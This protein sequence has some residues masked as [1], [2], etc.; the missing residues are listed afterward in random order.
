MSYSISEKLNI[1]QLLLFALP[2][3]MMFMFMSFYSIV[4]GIFIARYVS[5]DALAGLNIAY[6]VVGILIAVTFMF[7]SGGSAF[8]AHRMGMKRQITANRSFTFIALSVFIFSLVF[9][10]LSIIFVEEICSLLGANDTLLPYATTYL[11]ILMLFAPLNAMQWLFQCF[12]VTA[13]KPNLG[14]Y[15]TFIGG[16]LN[17]IFD[18]IFIVHMEMGISGAAYATVISWVAP[19]VGS[20][21][22]FMHN[23]AGLTFAKPHFHAIILGK[24]MFNG[25][26][27]MVGQLSQSFTS[28]IFNILMMKYVG[29]IGVAAIT[30]ALYADFLMMSAFFGF[31]IGV[32]PIISYHYGAKNMDYLKATVKKLFVIIFIASIAIYTI[33]VFGSPY[34]VGIFFEENSDVYIFAK[35]GLIIYSIS[36]LFK[37]INV[38]GSA[39]FTALGNGL[40][41]GIL[42]FF[43]T[44]LFLI[45]NIFLFSYFWEAQG[46]WIA[47]PVA[48]LMAV[49]VFLYYTK[50]LKRKYNII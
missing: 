12:L 35:A 38:F 1:K 37:G 34:I 25:S 8:V 39:L 21:I 33:C 28:V 6:P 11:F 31:S 17:I 26:S 9:G 22:Y 15:L 50:L 44:F 45:F 14:F 27:E 20:L 10:A 48:E 2:T 46:L 41:S 30:A 3:I 40:V 4:D 13:S 43:R 47:V 29:A 5:A 24:S 32:S 16:C 19:C 18:Y 36:F 23:K 7:G 42:A 49:F